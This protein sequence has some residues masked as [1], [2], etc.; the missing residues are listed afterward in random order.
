MSDLKP[1]SQK[2]PQRAMSSRP[3]LA[4]GERVP[5]GAF[6]CLMPVMA[7]SYQAD[8]GC[9][10]RPRRICAVIPVYAEPETAGTEMNIQT[11]PRPSEI[12]AILGLDA[13]SRRKSWGRR[14]LW[15]L[16]LLALARGGGWG[17]LQPAGRGT[18]VEL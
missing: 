15:L 17:V 10:A 3:V 4:V 14:A 12:E 6:S 11:P 8:Q 1:P 18:G 2:K 13:R 16:L 9:E 7:G 5:S